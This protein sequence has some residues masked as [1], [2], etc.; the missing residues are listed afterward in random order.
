MPGSRTVALLAAQVKILQ[1]FIDFLK[2]FLLLFVYMQIH[3]PFFKHH[4]SLGIGQTCG[5][6]LSQSGFPAGSG[7]RGNV[8]QDEEGEQEGPG[9]GC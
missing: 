5:L 7:D 2:L 1:I 9:E 3:V 8:V 6:I 4:C